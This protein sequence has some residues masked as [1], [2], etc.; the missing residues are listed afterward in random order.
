MS[1]Q[2]TQGYLARRE[3]GQEGG[4]R[5]G[6]GGREKNVLI[7]P[8]ES[9]CVIIS[10]SQLHTLP[11]RAKMSLRAPSMSKV[12]NVVGRLQREIRE[13]KNKTVVKEL[14]K[15]FIN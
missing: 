9:G 11:G 14:V 8:L 12:A 15:V 2:L 3:G 6:E 5:R 13:E 4:E 7:T 10:F 1:R